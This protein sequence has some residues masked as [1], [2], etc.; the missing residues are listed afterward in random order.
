MIVWITLVVVIL[1]LVSSAAV[2][3]LDSL[4]GAAVASSV[5]SLG[6]S[7][8][9]VIVLAPDVALT[10]AAVGAGLSG[11][12]MALGLRRLGLWRLEGDRG[13]AHPLTTTA[14]RLAAPKAPVEQGSN[15]APNQGSDRHA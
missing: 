15:Q 6:V 9:F 4:I 13:A 8:L 12:V 2:L 7:V 10:E 1:V 11:V 5:A 3:A 14:E